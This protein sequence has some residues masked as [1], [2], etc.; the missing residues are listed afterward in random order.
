MVLSSEVV[1]RDGSDVPSLTKS[2]AKI[3]HVLD[4][5]NLIRL[6]IDSYDW[7]KNEGLQELLEEISPIQDFTGK[8]M[9]LELAVPGPNGEPGYSFGELVRWMVEDASLDR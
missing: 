6:Q 7:F 2:Y 8:N 5:P 9:D 4:I 1:V 3:P